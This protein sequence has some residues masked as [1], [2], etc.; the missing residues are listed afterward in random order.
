MNNK[1]YKKIFLFDQPAETV[2]N[3][4][5]NVRGWWSELVEGDTANAGDVFIYRHKALHSSTQQLTEAERDKKVVWLVTASHLSFLKEKQDAWTGTVI[6]FEITPAGRQTQLTFTHHGLTP[7]IECFDACSGGWDYYLQS[8][9]DL[10]T[11]GKGQ[12]DQ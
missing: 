8:L 12:P 3:A 11:K 2:F 6:S 1:D 10:I 4:V 9:S 7:G 5:I